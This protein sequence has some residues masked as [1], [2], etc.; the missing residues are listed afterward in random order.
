MPEPLGQTAVEQEADRQRR[1]A[2][3]RQFAALPQAQGRER[4]AIRLADTT[5][6]TV[7][8]AAKVLASAPLDDQ[9]C[10]RGG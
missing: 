4:Q 3:W 10:V 5:D 2:R 9:A 6:L 7:E 1:Q 8:Q